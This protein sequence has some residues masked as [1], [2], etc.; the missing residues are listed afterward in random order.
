[1]KRGTAVEVTPAARHSDPPTCGKATEVL[2]NA[3]KPTREVVI[4][5]VDRAAATWTQLQAW[6]SVI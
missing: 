1:M 6:R 4:A 5:Q 3:P 2:G